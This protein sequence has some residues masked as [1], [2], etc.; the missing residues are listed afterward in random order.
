M[1]MLMLFMHVFM[2]MHAFQ[3]TLCLLCLL[4]DVLLIEYSTHFSLFFMFLNPPGDDIYED[5]T[6]GQDL[7]PGGKAEA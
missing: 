4:Y 5:E 7:T 3:D 1:F 2:N 6:A